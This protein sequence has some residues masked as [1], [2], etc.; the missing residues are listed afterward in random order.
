[1]VRSPCIRVRRDPRDFSGRPVKERFEL[2][3]VEPRVMHAH[4]RD[5]G[6]QPR[7]PGLKRRNAGHP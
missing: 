4:D 5:F 2:L 1:M 7:Q 3:D 6:L